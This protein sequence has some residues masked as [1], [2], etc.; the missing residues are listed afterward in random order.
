M[1][2][3]KR[4]FTTDD[5]LNGQMD[6]LRR[7]FGMLYLESDAPDGAGILLGNYDRTGEG[8]CTMYFSPKGIEIA[9]MMIKQYRLEEC[10]PPKNQEIDSIAVG[11]TFL[12]N[13]LA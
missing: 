10:D 2:W 7:E 12:L 13:T 11:D 1:S 8:A 4:T 6:L 3:Y 5:I 9:P